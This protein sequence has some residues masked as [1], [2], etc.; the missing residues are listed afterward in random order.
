MDIAITGIGVISSIGHDYASFHANL[1]ADRT[2]IGPPPFGERAE[3]EGVW[4][5][6]IDDFAAEAWMP[7]HVVAGTDTFAQYAIAASI[8][9]VRDAGFEAPPDAERTAVVL[10][11]A[12]SAVESVAASQ[13]GLTTQ[14]VEGIDR[15][16]H[17]KAWPNMA[18]AQ[19]ALRWQLHGPL[20]TVAT[21]CASSLD[22][23]GIA[24]RMIASGQAD[25]AIAGGADA[26]MCELRV[27]SGGRYGMFKPEADPA[28]ACRPFDRDRTGVILGE[29]A[30]VVFL[31]RADLAAARGARVHGVV[32]GYA[33]L[34]DGYHVSSP[35]PTGAW[36][37]RTIERAIGDAKLPRDAV[38]VVVA[39]GTGTKVGDIA[40]IRAIN[41]AFGDHA[42]KLHVTSIKGHIGHSAG[43]A[44][45]MGLIA[46]L[47]SMRA[48][49]LVPTA[50]TRTVDPEARFQ[51]PMGVPA[52]R[53]INTML[54]NAFGFGGQNAALVVT[55]G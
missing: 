46:G 2:K 51:V 6:S 18:A 44:G 29:G 43:G 9:A 24:A 7:P 3:F 11:T 27:L 10:G 21:A 38:D 23:I 19:V 8:D 37:A 34:S 53:A 22:A 17:I 28:T 1:A 50:G 41:T 15:K 13:R 4:V 47:M 26:S 39:H 42:E 32:R 36:E 16:F 54:V 25:C 33:S 5:S 30:G 55:R 14:G 12:L 35:E 52:V 31:E 40:E 20:L 48:G 45:A 49:A